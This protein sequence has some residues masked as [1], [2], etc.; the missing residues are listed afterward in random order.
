MKTI[1]VTGANG[2]LGMELRKL[3][4]SVEQFSFDFLDIEE[5]DL[6]NQDAVDYFFVDKNYYAI[7]NCAGYT[8]V[9]K[10]EENKMLADQVNG[11]VVKMLA[12]K[13]NEKESIFI[14]ISTDFVFDGRL[15]RPYNENDLPDP[16]SV[17]A[18]SK[19]LGEQYFMAYANRGMVIRTSWL[20]SEYGHNFVKTILKYGI[21]KDSLRVVFDQVG[22][23]TY[24]FDLARAIVYIL[25]L[26]KKI[27]G[28][29]IYHF[30]NEG[31]ASWYD[32][33]MAII[34]IAKIN[35]KI[36]PIETID[37]PLPAHRPAFSVM[38]KAKIK[39][40]FNLEIPHWKDSLKVCLQRIL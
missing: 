22:T 6:T 23:P 29:G 2:Q 28:K 34:E 39:N 27:Q 20:Y 33:A 11:T 37:Y 19:L 14:H 7:I 25:T 13:A 21:E 12:E 30:S 1:L 15:S 8:A 18:R 31:V 26:N 10:A 3:A 9:D 40:E 5:L 16:Q 4:G 36:I 35:C 24:A 32:F 17:Y 38:N